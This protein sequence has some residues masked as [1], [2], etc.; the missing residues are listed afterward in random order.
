MKGCPAADVQPLKRVERAVTILAARHAPKTPP[1][2][3][4]VLFERCVAAEV[5]AQ[6]RPI[7]RHST[8]APQNLLLGMGRRRPLASP[9]PCRDSFKGRMKP[10]N[11]ATYRRG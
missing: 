11:G 9:A 7:S 1:E 10:V 6:L 3:L 5:D 2:L 8:A 4:L